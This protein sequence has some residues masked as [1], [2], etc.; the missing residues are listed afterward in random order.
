M[1]TS[2]G[3]SDTGFLLRT[4]VQVLL[5]GEPAGE[6]TYRLYLRVRYVIDVPAGSLIVL[7]ALYEMARDPDRPHLPRRGILLIEPRTDSAL[8]IDPDR[9]TEFGR[10]AASPEADLLFDRIMASIRNVK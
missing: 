2:S 8:H 4:A 1:S 3:E 6:G 9:G 7:K 10:Y 5:T